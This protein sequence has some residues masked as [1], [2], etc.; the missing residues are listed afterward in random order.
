MWLNEAKINEW[1][2]NPYPKNIEEQPILTYDDNLVATEL[3]F[4][5]S[6]IY[7]MQYTSLFLYVYYY[8][9]ILLY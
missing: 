4:D 3:G 8:I 5:F 1:K 9:N 7:G 2:N 6:Y